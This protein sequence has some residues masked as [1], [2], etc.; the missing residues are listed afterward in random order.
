MVSGSGKIPEG[1]P[2]VQ[3]GLH[4]QPKP[5]KADKAPEGD[6]V[7]ISPRA[8]EAQVLASKVNLTP[9]VRP[10][11]VATSGEVS[12]SHSFVLP[13]ANAP[14]RKAEIPSG[15]AVTAAACFAV[16][17][18]VA[19]GAP[20]AV[21]SLLVLVALAD[22]DYGSDQRAGWNKIDRGGAQTGVVPRW[23]AARNRPAPERA[24][25]ILS[26]RTGIS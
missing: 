6:Q 8:A 11:A 5:V 1:I 12:P 3:R 24:A 2:P 15:L 7:T 22:V 19:Q 16:P 18:F 10:E 23:P 13:P 17:G 14:R 26:G 9:E 20:G 21:V 4:P 25:L